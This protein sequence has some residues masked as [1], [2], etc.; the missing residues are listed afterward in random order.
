LAIPSYLRCARDRINRELDLVSPELATC[1]WVSDGLAIHTDACNDLEIAVEDVF[2]GVEHR[3]CMRHL[4]AHFKL[5]GFKVQLFDNNLWPASLICSLKK[6]NYHMD[7]MYTKPRVNTYMENHHIK[8]WARSKFNEV[9]KVDYVNNN[10]AECFNSW[11]RKIK[12]L[13]LVDMLDKIR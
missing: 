6:H 10:L 9:C 13:H 12:G 4:A 5:Q 2:H 7:Q 11:I 1:Y 3:E 8:V